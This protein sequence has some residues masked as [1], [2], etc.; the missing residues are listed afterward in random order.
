MRL[1]GEVGP[2][3][4]GLRVV[5]RQEDV[6]LEGL[7]NTRAYCEVVDVCCG[8]NVVATYSLQEAHAFGLLMLAAA[9]D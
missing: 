4:R 9:R 6:N 5:R 7:K 8:N 1:T 2:V 3:G